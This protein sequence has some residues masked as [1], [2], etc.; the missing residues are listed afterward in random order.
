MDTTPAPSPSDS[1]NASENSNK[2]SRVIIYAV[3][4]ILVIIILVLVSF[5]L[6]RY[7][8]S[9]TQTVG[10]SPGPSSPGSELIPKVINTNKIRSFAETIE[11][12]NLNQDFYE[13]ADIILS[14][15]G[16]V[17]AVGPEKT[18]ENALEY[19]SFL[20][21]KNDQNREITYRFTNSEV[22]NMLVILARQGSGGGQ[23]INF[24]DIAAGDGVTVQQVVNLL[25]ETFGDE[26]TLI[27][28]R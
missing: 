16:V 3:A 10:L 11:N 20:K 7:R 14:N 26:Y 9:I 5:L 13:Q 8:T 1:T 24:S 22:N 27:V 19:A 21:L 28:K 18:T 6:S 17:T 12:S 25:E 23:K 2:Q 15:T 4:G